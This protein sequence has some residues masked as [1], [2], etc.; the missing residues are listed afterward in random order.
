[1]DG[2]TDGSDEGERWRIALSALAVWSV[3]V[4]LRIDNDN[5]EY[6]TMVYFSLIIGKVKS[7]NDGLARDH[8]F[9]NPV[10]TPAPE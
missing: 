6:L 1:V 2:L 5:L 10:E 7:Y 9:P 4:L 3:M 8:A